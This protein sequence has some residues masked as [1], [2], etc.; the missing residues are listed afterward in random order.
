MN[1]EDNLHISTEQMHFY[2]AL[3]PSREQKERSRSSLANYIP[4]PHQGPQKKTTKEATWVG[5]WN[6]E[7]RGYLSK[8]NEQA[9]GITKGPHA[10][11]IT[12][13]RSNLVVV[14]VNWRRTNPK[15]MAQI[16]HLN[17]FEQKHKYSSRAEVMIEWEWSS[18]QNGA[19]LKS[20]SYIRQGT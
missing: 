16:A 18:I 9:I 2:P 14:Q 7:T 4:V 1:I 11:A 3:L 15:I 6:K 17:W 12:E 13:T 8:L 10:T 19:L 5:T 20:W